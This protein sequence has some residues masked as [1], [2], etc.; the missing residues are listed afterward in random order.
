M[1]KIKLSLI[2][3]GNN[4]KNVRIFTS[5][6]ANN[7]NFDIESVEDIKLS[8]AEAFSFH[9]QNTLVDINYIIEEDSLMIVFSGIRNNEVDNTFKLRLIELWTDE[10]LI[11]GDTL[12]LKK[13]KNE[14]Y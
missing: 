11:E 2:S 5:S 1:E 8:A 10:F 12:S 3:N 9:K 7:M 13:V 6:I 14:G 4:L